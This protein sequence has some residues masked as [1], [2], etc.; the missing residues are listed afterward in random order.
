MTLS[1]WT[2]DLLALIDDPR[3]TPARIARLYREAHGHVPH[4]DW[5]IINAAIIDRWSVATLHQ[6]KSLAW[7]RG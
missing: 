7:R 5:K 6:V 3:A 1:G 2:N 4:Q